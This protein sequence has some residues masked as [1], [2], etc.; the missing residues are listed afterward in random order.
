MISV[1]IYGVAWP[2]ELGMKGFLTKGRQVANCTFLQFVLHI[3]YLVFTVLQKCL[4]PCMQALAV[5][6]QVAF[7]RMICV[8]YFVRSSGNLISCSFKARG[9][10]NKCDAA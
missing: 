1:L 8:L 10:T 7:F 4:R 2:L 9:G 5:I 6:E 3:K